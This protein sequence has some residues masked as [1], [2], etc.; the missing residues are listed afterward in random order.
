MKTIDDV[1]N[2]EGAVI[3]KDGKRVAVFKDAQ[4]DVTTLSAICT[5]MECE[6]E[7]NNLD[8]TWDCPC[9]GS[10]FEAKGKVLNGPATRNLDKTKL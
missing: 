8:K 6:V 5:H 2:N 7:W 10:R 3:D 1:K 4:A 9:H